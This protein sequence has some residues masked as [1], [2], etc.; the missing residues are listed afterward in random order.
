MSQAQP[1]VLLRPQVPIPVDMVYIIH[2]TP[3]K[4]A[5]SAIPKTIHHW[6]F[7]LPSTGAATSIYV[8]I[9][10]VSGY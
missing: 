8:V 1:T 4:N 3:H 2:P 10:L 9:R 6:V 7:A 5:E